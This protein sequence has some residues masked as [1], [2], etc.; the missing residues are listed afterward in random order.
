[1][2][3]ILEKWNDATQRSKK[4]KCQLHVLKFR[5]KT[6]M[7]TRS[8]CLYKSLIGLYLNMPSRKNMGLAQ[9]CRFVRATIIFTSKPRSRYILS[10]GI[11]E[12]FHLIT[13]TNSKLLEK[14]IFCVTNNK[15]MD[16][17]INEHGCLVPLV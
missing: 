13:N 5:P 1:M 7:F 4:T 3:L 2:D 9:F 11:H 16:A 14:R 17:H 6:N 10:F 15:N 12:L 8:M